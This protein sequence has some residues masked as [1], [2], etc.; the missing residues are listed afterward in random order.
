MNT[1]CSLAAYPN[2]SSCGDSNVFF[3]NSADGLAWTTYGRAA[4]TGTTGWQTDLYRS[5]L[6]Y[7]SSTNTLRVWYTGHAGNWHVGY[8][9]RNY[10]EFLASL[11]GGT[12]D[13]INIKG[14]GSLASSS[15]SDPV[16]RGNYS[17]KVTQGPGT[18]IQ[19]TKSQP[20]AQNN[21]YQEV[22]MYDDMD[23]TAFK[24]VRVMSPTINPDP[25][26]GEK[27]IGIG[28]WT[29]S[30]TT[31]YAYHSIDYLYTVTSIPRTQGWHKFGILL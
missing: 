8:T 3:A 10:S 20:A 22:D 7:D 6:Y 21:F 25:S 1:D 16:K 12:S 17:G 5:S 27:R 14:D 11:S 26:K 23:T 18:G 29:G 9:E 30:S 24:I 19:I 4:L 15:G 2:G 28:V 31:N 13:W